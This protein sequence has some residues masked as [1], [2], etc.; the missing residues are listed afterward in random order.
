MAGQLLRKKAGVFAGLVFGG[1]VPAVCC[2]AV[3]AHERLGD[4]GETDSLWFVLCD[5]QARGEVM[6]TLTRL[7]ATEGSA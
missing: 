6:D 1:N 2:A 4:L 3:Q 7:A 5:D